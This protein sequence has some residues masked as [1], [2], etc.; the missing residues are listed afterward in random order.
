MFQSSSM[1]TGI[2]GDWEEGISIMIGKAELPLTRIV[3]EDVVRGGG[4]SVVGNKPH[5]PR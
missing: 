1:V 5:N 4:G 3:D 2:I